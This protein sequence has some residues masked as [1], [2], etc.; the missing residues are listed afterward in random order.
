MIDREEDEEDVRLVHRVLTGDLQ[1]YETLVRRHQRGVYFFCL[2]SLNNREEAEDAA[3]EVFLRAYR[4][5]KTFSLEKRFKTWLYAIAVNHLR[6]RWKKQNKG[7]IDR[8][9]EYFDGTPEIVGKDP[10]TVAMEDIEEER[11][12]EAVQRLPENLRIVVMLYY[13]EELSVSEVAATLGIGEEGVKSRLFR[14][15][16]LLR[17]SLEEG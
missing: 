15:R 11:I 6:S 14:A 17:Q 12:R 9:K 1:A 4:S 10:E 3:Q 7:L 13:F 8:I 5:L 2:A 16:K